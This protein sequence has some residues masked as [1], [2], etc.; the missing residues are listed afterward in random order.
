MGLDTTHDAWHG[1]YTAFHLWRTEIAGRIGADFEE[2]CDNHGPW[3]TEKDDP[4]WA[5]LHHPDCEGEL[6][7]AQ[8]KGIADRL[9]ELL[10]QMCADLYGTENEWMALK[11]G[12]FIVGCRAAV[13]A[14][15]NIEFR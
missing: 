3:P 11:A 9:Q 7:P 4:L 1:S 13:E 6:A 15:E 14:G 2:L 12:I 10:P 5:L 8:C